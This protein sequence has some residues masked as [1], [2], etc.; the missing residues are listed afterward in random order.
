MASPAVVASSASLSPWLVFKEASSVTPA[1]KD[2]EYRSYGTAPDH[3]VGFYRENHR[4]QTYA[5]AQAQARKYGALD[6]GVEMGI[7][8]APP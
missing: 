1:Q 2:H 8:Y 4:R 7:W 6:S 5:F 3:V